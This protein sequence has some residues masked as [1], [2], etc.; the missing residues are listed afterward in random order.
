VVPPIITLTAGVIRSGARFGNRSYFFNARYYMSS[1]GRFL[2][3]DPGNAG[4]DLTDPQTWN[5]YSYVRG[6]PLAGVDPLGLVAQPAPGQPGCTW[7][8]ATNTL[9]CGGGGGCVAEGSEGCIPPPCWTLASGCGAPVSGTP[10]LYCEPDIIAGMK[11]IWMQ[12]GN[13]M[14]GTEASFNV[15][16]TPD[17]YSLFFNPFTNQQKSQSFRLQPNTFANFH[18]HP[19]SGSWEPSSPSNNAPWLQ[20][21]PVPLTR[22]VSRGR[23]Y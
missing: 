22:R 13:G 23:R 17:N 15:N 5:G 11:K 20:G 6:N 19:N 4:A 3:P 8:P 16:G 21:S 10:P 2:S 12:S 18:V 9:N 1:Y 14:N 7:D